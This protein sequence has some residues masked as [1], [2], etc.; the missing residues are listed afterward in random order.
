MPE[1]LI[2]IVTLSFD[3]TIFLAWYSPD[4]VDQVLEFFSRCL[5]TSV[6]ESSPIR[7]TFYSIE[8]Q[9]EVRTLFLSLEEQVQ[10]LNLLEGF[11]KE[12][13]V[14]YYDALVDDLPFFC[15]IVLE[16]GTSDF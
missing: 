3:T 15:D 6:T 12:A 7:L 2:T 13:P 4:E 8:S 10:L 16:D 1:P 5:S 11:R 14:R 9:A